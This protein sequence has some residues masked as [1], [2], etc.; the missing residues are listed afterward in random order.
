MIRELADETEIEAG[1][2]LLSKIP[3]LKRAFTNRSTVKNE[4]SLLILVKPTIIIQTEQEHEA[5]PQ[6]AGERG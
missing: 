6:L 4:Q 2:P 5:F 3:L 1:V